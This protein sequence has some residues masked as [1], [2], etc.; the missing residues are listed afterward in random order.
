MS[1][2]NIKHATIPCVKLTLNSSCFTNN[3]RELIQKKRQ[4]IF[5]FH[6]KNNSCLYLVYNIL[7][8]KYLSLKNFSFISLIMVMQNSLKPTWN[9]MLSYAMSSNPNRPIYLKALSSEFLFYV[10]TAGA[11]FSVSTIIFIFWS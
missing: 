9:R 7:K 1:G 6:I 8:K 3:L 2:I 10:L 5:W 4:K 11:K